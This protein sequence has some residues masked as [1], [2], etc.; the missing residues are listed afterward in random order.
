M[1]SKLEAL[2]DRMDS[3][4]KKAADQAK[5]AD[6]ITKEIYALIKRQTVPRNITVESVKTLFTEEQ[7]GFLK[8]SDADDHVRVEFNKFVPRVM[9][10]DVA[11]RLKSVRGKYFEKSAT[12]APHFKISK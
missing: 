11:N 1:T 3:Y 5:E 2:A 10:S 12:V 7:H 9:F 6:A 8:V 4:A